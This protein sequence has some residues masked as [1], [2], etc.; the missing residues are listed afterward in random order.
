M[1]TVQRKP[2]DVPFNHEIYKVTDLS[3][4]FFF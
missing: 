4:F 2:D 3:F 1:I